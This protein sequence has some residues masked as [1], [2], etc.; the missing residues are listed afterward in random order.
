MTY[1]YHV[2][3]LWYP[4]TSFLLFVIILSVVE[5][6][7]QDWKKIREEWKNNKKYDLHNTTPSILY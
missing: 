3:M 7:S 2:T 4:T 1:T 6:V 5:E